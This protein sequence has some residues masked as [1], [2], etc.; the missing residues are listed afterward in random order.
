MDISLAQTFLETARCTH[1]I[2]L[3]ID[4]DKLDSLPGTENYDTIG[5]LALSLSSISIIFSYL[6]VESFINY[7]LY[8]LWRR[9]R[10]AHAQSQ[11]E[12]LPNARSKAALLKEFYNRFGIE[13]KFEQLKRNKEIRE[14]SH[15]IKTV[16]IYLD[17]KPIHEADHALW[18]KFLV[19]VKESRHFLVHPYPDPVVAQKRLS[20]ILTKDKLGVYSTTAASV[21]RHFY[22]QQGAIPPEWL[23][24]NKLFRFTGVQFPI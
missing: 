17:V 10:D 24:D 12:S 9:S 22:V 19:L 20:Q 4:R 3:N 15:R 18:Q 16:C 8:S 13:D 5:S 14:L 6:A 1:G 7:Q 2:P 21:I 11:H 23:E